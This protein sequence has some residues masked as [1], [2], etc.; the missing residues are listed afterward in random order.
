MPPVAKVRGMEM[1]RCFEQRDLLASLLSSAPTAFDNPHH[2]L[3]RLTMHLSNGN[4]AQIHAYELK[5]ILS[6]LVDECKCDLHSEI[7]GDINNNTIDSE[8][9]MSPRKK[10]K[11]APSN[12][13]LHSILK[14]VQR[15]IYQRYNEKEMEEKCSNNDDDD[16]KIFLD[17][18]SKSHFG[19]N[20]TLF[21]IEEDILCLAFELAVN[22]VMQRS[23]D[24]K[25]SNMM[26][27]HGDVCCENVITTALQIIDSVVDINRHE[28]ATRRQL[29]Q[30][31]HES[32]PPSSHAAAKV[33]R[34]TK[35][36][37]LL[38]PTKKCK[39]LSTTTKKA[40][41]VMEEKYPKQ[42]KWLCQFRIG[43]NDTNIESMDE[44][45]SVEELQQVHYPSKPLSDETDT[46]GDDK[47]SNEETNTTNRD[48]NFVIIRRRIETLDDISLSSN[49]SDEEKNQEIDNADAMSQD[50]PMGESAAELEPKISATDNVEDSLLPTPA[51]PYERLDRETSELRLTLLDMPPNEASSTEVV[52]HTVE[53]ITNLLSKYGEV[54]GAAGIARCGDI[55]GGQR[56]VDSSTPPDHRFPL[57]DAMVASL[58]KEL[59]TDATGSLRAKSFLRAFV[60]PLMVEMNPTVQMARDGSSATSKNQ[61]KSASRVLTSLLTTIAR[62]RPTECV[63]SVIVPTL[64][65]RKYI[66]PSS[67]AASEAVFEPTRFQCELITRILKGKDALSSQALALLVEQLLPEARAAGACG[68]MKWTENTMPVLA[69]CLNRHPKL[70]DDVVS[71]LA[72]EI[73]YHLSPSSS[74]ASMVKS[75]KI[76]TLF[77]AFVSKYGAQVKSTGKVDS[78]KESA[79]R[80]KTFMSKTIGVA[81]KK[82]S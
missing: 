81:L 27:N 15:V 77:H 13:N 78:L 80:L 39:A 34:R 16:D 66:M 69:A 45:T 56:M 53:Q 9:M 76:S 38:Q 33:S 36:E 35:Y 49:D 12:N 5:S 55:F 54:D 48:S 22:A 61:S 4:I 17:N 51:S 23:E 1:R 30:S 2:N 64:V 74:T 14:F 20:D 18:E 24:L 43:A 3:G 68:G 41:S 52:R 28:R 58:L 44:C 10:A 25:S 37:H 19:T 47:T 73:S 57:N 60:L 75:M 29:Y 6:A 46:M 11:R 70:A 67:T 59:L 31:R 82:L 50:K 7:S 8:G 32:K 72:D 42:W 71:K 65:L 21:Q 62:D 79:T 26:S 63:V 40:M